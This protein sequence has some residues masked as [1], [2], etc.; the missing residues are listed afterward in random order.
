MG[1]YDI[2]DYVSNSE[3][4]NLRNAAYVREG[5]TAANY[6][7]GNL[8]H[9]KVSEEH[10]ITG[11]T[12]LKESGE[13][14]V[15]EAQHINTARKM[16]EAYKSRSDLKTMFE[17]AKV[18]HAFFREAF[19]IICEGV[20]FTMRVK[21]KLDLFRKGIIGGDF[22]TT[23]CTNEANFLDTLTYFHIDQQVAW[24]MDIARLDRFMIIGLSKKVKGG[25]YQVFTWLINRGDDLYN[26]GK[27]KYSR[28]AMRYHFLTQNF[29]IK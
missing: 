6:D 13:T 16:A 3:L 24:Y 18:E 15:F 8:V 25:K 20:T 12:L 14:V 22:K 9:A 21:C 4:N 23:V 19:E 2:H 28:L 29:L 27:E 17:G 1:Y 10:R 11:N 5:G 26:S 7:F